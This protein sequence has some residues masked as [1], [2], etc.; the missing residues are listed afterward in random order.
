MFH[1][2]QLPIFSETE[3]SSAD[4]PQ[5]PPSSGDVST[6]R[7]DV[8][9]PDRDLTTSASAA[10][11]GH[12]QGII[13]LFTDAIRREMAVDGGRLNVP[14]PASGAFVPF[15]WLEWKGGAN[16]AG[17]N[18][19]VLGGIAGE[20]GPEGAWA[21][22]S[23]LALVG[24]ALAA[25]S[26][27]R[28]SPALFGKSQSLSGRIARLASGEL[29]ARLGV[30]NLH[31]H[32]FWWPLDKGP[33][34]RLTPAIGDLLDDL[35]A[36][37]APDGAALTALFKTLSSLIPIES[38]R[39][40]GQISTPA[41]LAA[42]ALDQIGWE[43][44]NQLLDPACGS[45]TILIE[46]LQRRVASPS[47]AGRTA[48]HVLHGL[49]GTDIDPLAAL[50]TKAAMI[51]T[52]SDHLPSRETVVLP[53]FVADA[54]DPVTRDGDGC[55]S[56]RAKGGG[57]QLSLPAN[58]ATP[59]EVFAFFDATQLAT[60]TGETKSVP[61]EPRAPGATAS[62]NDGSHLAALGAFIIEARNKACP[63]PVIASLADRFAAG[64]IPSVSHIVT[65]PPWLRWSQLPAQYAKS[66]EPV[67]KPLGFAGSFVG[68][69]ETDISISLV[70]QAASRL[71][72][73]GR[74]GAI[75]SASL[76]SNPSGERLRRPADGG[77]PVAGIRSVEDLKAL[78]PFDLGGHPALVIIDEGV[79]TSYPLPYR[80][81][82]P[83]SDLAGDRLA[84]DRRGQCTREELLAVPV[85]G[86]I[87]GPWLKGT[88]E[89]L[90]LWAR[91][92][93]ANA[94]SSYKARKGVTTDRNGIYWVRAERSPGRDDLVV[95]EN[96]PDVG[97]ISGIPKVRRE[98]EPTHLFPMV[99]GRGVRPF[100]AEID[101]AYH[102]LV[103]Q[104]GMHGDPDLPQEC[105]ETFGFLS[106]F[107]GELERR[108]SYRRFQKGRPFWSLWSTGP[109]SFAPYKVLWREMSSRFGAAYIGPVEDALLGEKVVVPDHKLYCVALETRAEAQYLTGLLN[110]RRVAEAVSAYASQLSLGTSVVEYLKLPRFNADDPDH[111]RVAR[112]CESL[113]ATQGTGDDLLAELDV[114]A[115]QI[116]GIGDG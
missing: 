67:C 68:G 94:P 9:A 71:A 50:W 86:T 92:F 2:L 7:L 115:G 19:S 75:L 25:R 80:R 52:I 49:Y 35:L 13:P 16:A 29:F 43:P 56:H 40:L 101:P 6:G 100:V 116:L 91:L 48:R 103:P 88:A 108:S 81:W 57:E 93:D 28:A 111:Q 109:Y 46:A 110:A 5:P 74:M 76:F 73:G 44:A 61:P 102:V 38:R 21:A 63:L 84:D 17:T 26:V 12:G 66:I 31:G 36:L 83:S 27:P 14:W 33:L 15:G 34:R 42:H 106:S 87:S 69:V 39:G 30:R 97:R 20:G 55:L 98:V 22:R 64:A 72:P 70:V 112:A 62:E 95:V 54:V 89:Q 90:H 59:D 85:P 114:A 107:Q 105:P 18:G 82:T 77:A 79:S 51:A 8:G 45:G 58:V 41:W 53:V 23:Y 47:I 4:L 1:Q 78:R 65:N 99:R 11:L 32:G 96:D 104:R 37:A 10:I 113:V 24:L 3:N 60:A